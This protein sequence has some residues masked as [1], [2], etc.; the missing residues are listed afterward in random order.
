MANYIDAVNTKTFNYADALNIATEFIKKANPDSWN[1]EGDMP[2]SF[3]GKRSYTF[4]IG[5]EDV[6]L[7]IYFEYHFTILGRNCL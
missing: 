4:D 6:E 1:G 2:D 5:M 3:D 7:D